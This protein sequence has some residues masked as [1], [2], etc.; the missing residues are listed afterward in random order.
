[1]SE[2]VL[3]V[4]TA[5]VIVIGVIGTIVPLLPG[6]ALVWVAALVWGF[7]MSFGTAGVVAMIVITLLFSAGIYLSLRIPQKSAAAQGLSIRGTLFGVALAIGVGIVIPV[8]GIPLGFVLGVWIVRIAETG[9][10]RAAF[11]SALA[12]TAALLRASA[13]QFGIGVAMG[14]VWLLWA[15]SA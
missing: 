14:T 7:L 3:F 9:N 2:P 5:A 6:L 13:A 1:M 10:A 15:L 11:D 4:L 12:T 8:V